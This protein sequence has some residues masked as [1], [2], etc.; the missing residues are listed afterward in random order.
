MPSLIEDFEFIAKRAD[1]IRAAHSRDLGLSS[2]A[3][4]E[5]PPSPAGGVAVPIP[6]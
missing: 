4:P 1:E 5:P 3:V 6:T 2:P